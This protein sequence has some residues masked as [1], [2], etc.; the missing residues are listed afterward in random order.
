MARIT[1]PYNV[2]CCPQR[3][4][5]TR[6]C[7]LSHSRLECVL[8]I[9]ADSHKLQ[10]KKKEELFFVQERVVQ[11]VILIFVLQSQLK[12]MPF[13]GVFIHYKTVV[14]CF[15]CFVKNVFMQL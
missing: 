3:K 6:L 10:K 13:T 5:T 15:K 1:L 12:L 2:Q 7:R 14:C 9:L 4:A 8:K 11:V